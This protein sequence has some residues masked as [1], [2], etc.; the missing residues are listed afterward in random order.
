[1]RYNYRHTATKAN[2]AK[3]L[4]EGYVTN[5]KGFYD[6]ALRKYTVPDAMKAKIKDERYLYMPINQN[7]IDINS[8]L[9]QNSAYKSTKSKN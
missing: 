5:Y 6:L 3:K 7:E 2:P 1:M 8:N 4:N 9:V